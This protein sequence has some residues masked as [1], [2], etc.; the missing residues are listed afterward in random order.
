M[1]RFAEDGDDLVNHV[2]GCREV[3]TVP[4]RWNRIWRSM[5]GT[6]SAVYGPCE[7]WNSGA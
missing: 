4:Q 5:I 3:E 6:C 2:S 1:L 7:A